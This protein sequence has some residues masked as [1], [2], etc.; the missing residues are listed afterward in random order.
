MK[1]TD[2]ITTKSGL[3][4]TLYLADCLAVLPTLGKVDACITDPPYGVNACSTGRCFGTSNAAPVNEYAPIVGDD[5]PFA[6]DALLALDCKLCLFGA[7]HYADKLPA[8]PTWLIWD[9]RD[10][11]RSNPLAD[12]EMAWTTFGGPARLK[13]HRWMGMIRASDDERGI[14][15]T[16]KP[17]AVMEWCVEQARL[18]P[19]QTI[20]DPFMGSGTTGVAALRMG[21]NF[22]GIEISDKYYAIAKRRIMMEAAQGSLFQCE[23]PQPTHAR[24]AEIPFGDD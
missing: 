11:T 13:A 14:H 15:P 1:P 10:G 18:A 16:Q 5:A 21:C 3:T 6:P 7:N 24:T 2:V 23:K 20:L 22:V 12:C 9:K 8:S 19:G 17:L 4:A